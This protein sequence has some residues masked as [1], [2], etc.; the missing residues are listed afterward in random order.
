MRKFFVHTYNN[1]KVYEV[2][3]DEMDTEGDTVKFYTD[4]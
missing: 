4:A 2:M 3:A 1:N